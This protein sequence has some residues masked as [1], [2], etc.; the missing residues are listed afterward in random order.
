MKF[1]LVLMLFGELLCP[2]VAAVRISINAGKEF[3]TMYQLPP[4]QCL[5]A[6]EARTRLGSGVLAARELCI[7]PSALSHR[8]K[9][10]EEFTQQTL[11]SKASGEHVLTAAGEA[12]LGVVRP[13]L[14]ALNGYGR[15]THT[16]KGTTLQRVRLCSPPTFATQILVPRLA[17]LQKAF[18]R[19]SLELHLSV[20][21]VGLKAEEV[22]I[23][24]RFGKGVYPGYQVRLILEEQVFPVCSPEY[25]ERF[26]PFETFQDIGKG[27]LLQCVIEPWQPWLDAAKVSRVEEVKGMQFVDIGLFVEAA[28]CGHGIA[29][30]RPMMAE[31]LLSTGRIVPLFEKTAWPAYSYYATCLPEAS[32]KPGVQEI[33]EWLE[34]NVQ[35]GMSPSH[36]EPPHCHA[37][38][39]IKRH[40]TDEPIG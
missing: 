30:A 8:L 27:K 20:P 18:P 11:F 2:A 12:Y 39:V 7:T 21:L 4:I 22:D 15:D 35:L 23:E 16:P 25:R 34:F 36:P 5:I 40:V 17:L 13:A 31:T 10:L 19:L 14:Q 24:I 26:G 6:F 32:D 33:L 9:Q 28:A 29:L 3:A 38:T 1:A 37:G